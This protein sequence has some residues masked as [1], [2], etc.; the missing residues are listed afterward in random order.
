MRLAVVELRLLL[1]GRVVH[2][3]DLARLL[4]QQALLLVPGDL[5]VL[6]DHVAGLAAAC[7]EAVGAAVAGEVVL[8]ANVAAVDHGEDE[9]HAQAA[10][11][12]ESEA[13]KNCQRC[14]AR[15]FVAKLTELLQLE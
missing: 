1:M 7:A 12:E 5:L 8:C 9:G 13:L 10:K 6:L 4:A 2:A 14:V 11:A 3:V 15:L